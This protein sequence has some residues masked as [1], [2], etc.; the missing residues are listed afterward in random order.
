MKDWKNDFTA[1]FVIGALLVTGIAV[2]LNM[3]I[4]NFNVGRFDLTADQVYRLSPSVRTILSQ[5]EAPIDITY[6]VSSSEKMPTQWKNLERDVIDKLRELEMASDGKLTYTVFDPSAEEER[7][8]L[9]S[10]KAGTKDDTDAPG[11]TRKKIAERLFEKG[12]IPFGVQSTE[13]DEFAI[14][15]VYSSLVLSYL[16]R[17]EDVIEEVRPETFGSLEYE[18]MSRIYKLVANRRP[19]IGFYPAQPEIPPHMMQHYQQAPPDMYEATVRVLR[20]AGY[21][22]TRTNIKKDDP[23]PE[24]IQTMLVMA[25]QPLAERQLY[26]LDKLIQEGVSVILAAQ[27]H[28]YQVQYTTPGNFE[29]RGMPTRVNLNDLVRHYGFEFDT[30]MFMDQNTAYIQVPVYSTRNLGFM[31]VREQRL[32]PVT[33]PVM[34]R[35]NAENINNRLSISNKITELFYLYGTRLIVHDDRMKQ[36]TLSHKTLFT[37]SNVSWTRDGMGYGPVNTDPPPQEAVLRRQPLG[38]LVEGSFK[39]KFSDGVVPPWPESDEEAEKEPVPVELSVKGKFGKILAIGCANMFKS[40]ML[41]SIPSHV[42]LLRNTVDALTLGDDLINIRSKTITARR[43][44]TIGPAG[45]ALAKGFVVWF[46][47]AVFVLLGIYLTVKR[48]KK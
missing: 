48:K 40:D 28:N 24:N 31:Q 33:K 17:K 45:K 6:Y 35:V 20:E 38:I 15:R 30:R 39:P 19:R 32:E 3:V 36:D 43:I 46:S 8:A 29:L 23:I 21:D 10:E 11:V 16:D 41:Q 9:E 26:E 44:R 12:V 2:L 7:E 4:G 37:S 18:I 14:K 47:P 25:D 34:I 13:R 5:L 1:R 42:A 22:V 27:M